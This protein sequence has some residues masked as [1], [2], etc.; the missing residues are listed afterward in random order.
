[1]DKPPGN[2]FDMGNI[3]YRNTD[4]PK[5]LE[6]PFFTD[7]FNNKHHFLKM[8]SADINVDLER[9]NCIC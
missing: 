2:S 8:T 9:I 6:D 1:M 3:D 7:K 4:V 5:F